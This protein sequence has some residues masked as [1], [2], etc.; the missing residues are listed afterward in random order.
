MRA[1]GAAVNGTGNP[2]AQVAFV[3]NPAQAIR[4]NLPAPQYAN[5]IVSG[6]MTAGSVGAIDTGG[7]AMIVGSRCLRCRRDAT[8]HMENATP[9]ALGTGAQG[10]GVLAVPMR[11]P[12]Q[13]DLVAL[14]SVL[15]T[16]WAKRRTGAAA[17]VTGAIW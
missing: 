3:V 9:L 16:S 1:L 10:S 17:L 2:D 11:S 15:R 7:I 13:E 14:R 4:I 5:L 12:F 6:Y 8:L